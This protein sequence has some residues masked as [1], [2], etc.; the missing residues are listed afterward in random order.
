V[1]GA[2][3]QTIEVKESWVNLW[4]FHKQ[5]C[6]VPEINPYTTSGQMLNNLWFDS[7]KMSN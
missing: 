1:N 2:D 3:I 5:M 6:V 7:K 4:I